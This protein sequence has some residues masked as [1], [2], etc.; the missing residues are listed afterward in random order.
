M[1]YIPP[2]GLIGRRYMFGLEK[3][4]KLTDYNNS[5]KDG[6]ILLLNILENGDMQKVEISDIEEYLTV[7][8]RITVQIKKADYSGIYDSR[9]E[10]IE[11]NAILISPPSDDG[12][13]IPMTP[14]TTVIVEFVNQTGRFRFESKVT[15]RRTQGAMSITEIS[16]PKTISKNQL[17]E[18]YRVETRIKAKL[19]IFYAGVPDKN[20]KI[21]HKSID[22]VVIDISG[23]GGKLITPSWIEQNQEFILDLSDELKELEN[24]P[25]SAIRVKRIQEKTEV[26]FRFNFTKESERN[27]IIKYVF[28]RQI[29]LKQTFG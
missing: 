11:K 29:E 18:F 15:G 4:Y 21:P 20:M 9:V 22:C 14:G 7:N 5:G 24:L 25:C 6:V 19:K 13:P 8:T 16:V 1:E 3:I 28:K 2:S 10:D 17:R 12:K 27:A 23:G 26:S